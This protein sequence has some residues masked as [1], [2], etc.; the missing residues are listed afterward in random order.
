GIALSLGNNFNKSLTIKRLA[1]MNTKKVKKHVLPALVLS[2]LL[3]F[4]LVFTISCDKSGAEHSIVQESKEM[5]SKSSISNG[6][7]FVVVENMPKFR[8]DKSHE[9]F[10]GYIAENLKYP[11]IA[12]ENGI[13]GKVFVSFIVEPDGSVSNVEVVRGVDPSIDKEAVRVVESSPK[14]EPGTQRGINVRVQFTFPIAF[15]LE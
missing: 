14:W 8:G 6:E 15:S 10:R 2:F 5:E 3:I 9:I 4:S 12:L 13:Q 7:V 1:M 11:V